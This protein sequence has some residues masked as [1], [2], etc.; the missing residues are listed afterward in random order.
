MPLDAELIAIR[1]AYAK[2][3]LAIAGVRDPRLEQAYASVPRED[4]L[5][6]GPWTVGVEDETY[7]T[8]P[9][10]DPAHLYIDAVVA[11]LPERRLNNGQPSFHVRLMAHAAPRPGEHVVHIGAG[12]GYYSAI[13]AELVAPGGHVTA[14]EFDAEL[15]G[16][17]R[18]N[19]QRW[20]NVQVIHGDGTATP[21]QK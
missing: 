19:L 10:D 2:Q 7:V 4:F 12:A 20:P 21:F 11:I 1:R 18:S 3:L 16:R 15:A 6:P 5:G 9:S 17:A 13:L 8:T 14:V